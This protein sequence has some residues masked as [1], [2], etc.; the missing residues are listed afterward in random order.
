MKTIRIFTIA[1]ML[2]AVS[3]TS[4]LKDNDSSTTGLSKAEKDYCASLVKGNYTGNLIYAANRCDG[5]LWMVS[6]LSELML[7]E[8]ASVSVT[9]LTF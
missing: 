7:H 1:S 4:C 5:K 3:L 2:A 9:S 8:I 6:V